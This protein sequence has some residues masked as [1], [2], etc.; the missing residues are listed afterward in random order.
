VVVLATTPVRLARRHLLEIL[1]GAEVKFHAF[2]PLSGDSI[3]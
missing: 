3:R 2:Q 1:G